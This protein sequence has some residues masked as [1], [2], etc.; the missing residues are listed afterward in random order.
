MRNKPAF[1]FIELLVVIFIYSLLLAG[2]VDIFIQAQRAQRKVAALEKLQD[3][4]RFLIQTITQSFQAGGLDYS[5][6]TQG[7]GQLCKRDLSDDSTEGVDIL[8]IKNFEGKTIQFKHS[9]DPNECGDPR[10]S[11]CVLVSD[12]GG[13][14]WVRGS[15]EGVRI[16]T[17][18]FYISPRKNPF[19]LDADNEYLSHQQP[20]LTV[21]FGGTAAIKG[22]KETANIFIQTTI[23][24]REYKR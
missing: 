21:V 13:E 11:P 6:Y 4:A 5:C 12:N 7:Q 10:S 3:D 15:S 24:S 22:F 18:S 17:L 8:A 9:V 2:T 20:R 16:D 1:T 23:S 14:S 19:E